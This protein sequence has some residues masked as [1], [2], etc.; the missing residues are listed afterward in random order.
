MASTR[1]FSTGANRDTADGKLEYLGFLCPLTLK[2]FAKYMHQ[3][4]TLADGSVRDSDNWKKGMPLDVYHHSLLRHVMDVWL[5]YDDHGDAATEDL[6]DSLCAVIF[7]AQ[8]LLR[9][10]LISEDVLRRLQDS[11][12]DYGPGRCS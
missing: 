6:Q 5:H 2:R 9:E 11:E 3:H 4:R 12:G 7:N 1:E 10:L 8:G